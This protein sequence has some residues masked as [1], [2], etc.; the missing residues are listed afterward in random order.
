MRT[1]TIEVFKKF[2]SIDYPV[3][4]EMLS[5][6]F[7]IS[8][9][10]IRNEIQEINQFLTQKQLPLISTVRNK[11]FVIN[12][13]QDQKLLIYKALLGVPVSS[14]LSKDE[15]QFDLL[16]SIAFSASPTILSIKKMFILY[17]KV[18]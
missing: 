11:G 9:R 13:S 2:I 14:V 17:R 7:Q 15:R 18:F 10:T 4:V 8:V 12:A 1:R 3:T 5:E 16:L 6:E